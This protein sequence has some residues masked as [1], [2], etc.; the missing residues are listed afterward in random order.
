MVDAGPVVVAQLSETVADVV[1]PET[2][3]FD[4]D[5][6]GTI[7]RIDICIRRLG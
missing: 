6:D 3:V 2:I 4:L 1:T 7:S 5:G